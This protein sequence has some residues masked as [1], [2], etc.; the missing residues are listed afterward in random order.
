MYRDDKYWIIGTAL[1]VVGAAVVMWT[2]SDGTLSRNATKADIDVLRT[3][4]IDRTEK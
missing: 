4:I 1:I 3:L 2:F